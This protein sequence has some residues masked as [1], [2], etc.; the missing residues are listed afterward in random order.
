MTSKAKKISL[1]MDRNFG[2]AQD[3]R[4]QLGVLRSEGKE[5]ARIQNTIRT[6]TGLK[7]SD[8]FRHQHHIEHGNIFFKIPSFFKY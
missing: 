6:R 3:A 8:G 7:Y 5:R 2:S 4:S 1:R